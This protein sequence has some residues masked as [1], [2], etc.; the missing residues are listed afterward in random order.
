MHIYANIKYLQA[1]E[2]LSV[3][4]SPWATQVST[5]MG[6]LQIKKKWMAISKPNKTVLEKWR[7]SS[8]ISSPK[9]PAI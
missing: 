4:H 9:D 2:Y 8:W 6:V 1:P 5:Q 3:C 7:D